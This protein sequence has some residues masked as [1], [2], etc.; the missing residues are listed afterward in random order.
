MKRYIKFSTSSK[1][2]DYVQ[3]IMPMVRSCGRAGGPDRTGIKVLVTS[4]DGTAKQGEI[5][6]G[7]SD[8]TPE[9][10]SFRVRFVDK[11]GWSYGYE[12][13]TYKLDQVE[14]L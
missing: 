5:V 11:R 1:D 6:G 7:Y 9:G 8:G 13:G 4:P 14:F 12:E 3:S 2:W 10:T